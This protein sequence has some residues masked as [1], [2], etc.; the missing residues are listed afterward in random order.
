M[1]LHKHWKN[2]LPTLMNSSALLIA[3]SGRWKFRDPILKALFWLSDKV[4]KYLTSTLSAKRFLNV[5]WRKR[6]SS[7]KNKTNNR[8]IYSSLYYNPYI[9]GIFRDILSIS[10]FLFSYNAKSGAEFKLSKKKDKNQLDQKIVKRKKMRNRK[11]NLPIYL[12]LPFKE[13]LCKEQISYIVIELIKSLLFQRQQI[14]MTVDTLRNEL[15][16]Y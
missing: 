5:R 13:I 2:Y 4:T 12:D 16:Y 15:R 3:F 7:W 1:T 14:P 9:F 10:Y 11:E 8:V 6:N